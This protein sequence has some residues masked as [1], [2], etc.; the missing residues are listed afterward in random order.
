MLFSVTCLP[1]ALD[2][3]F[4]AVAESVTAPRFAPWI[5]K[6]AAASKLVQAELAAFGAPLRSPVPRV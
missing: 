4:A 3:A 2:E 5:V 1:A 6:E